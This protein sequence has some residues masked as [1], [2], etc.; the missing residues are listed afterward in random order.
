M[1]KEMEYI[2]RELSKIVGRKII[3]FR[4]GWEGFDLIL[5]D[6]TEVEVYTRGVEEPPTYAVVVAEY[7]LYRVPS[8]SVAE[9]VVEELSKRAVDCTIQEHP[10]GSIYVGVYKGHVRDVEDMCRKKV[11][12][13]ETT[14]ILCG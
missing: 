13:D 9:R 5:D 10:D 3:G 4:V 6:G 14:G 7:K 12:S 1:K 8:L 2:A 11:F